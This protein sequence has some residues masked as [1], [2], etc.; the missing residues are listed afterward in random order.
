MHTE[1]REWAWVWNPPPVYTYAQLGVCLKQYC[2][3]QPLSYWG[4]IPHIRAYSPQ[5]IEEQFHTSLTATTASLHLKH[6]AG[7][8]HYE[9]THYTAP[10]WCHTDSPHQP[11]HTISLIRIATTCTTN[12][13]VITVWTYKYFQY[14][15]VL[16]K[17][18]QPPTTHKTATPSDIVKHARA[19][20]VC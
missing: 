16:H 13:I 8:C 7:T 20:P 11:T 5:S 1:C 9:H 6:S 3:A 2:M 19:T 15:K 17:L 12:A 14:S 4:G 18:W 10:W